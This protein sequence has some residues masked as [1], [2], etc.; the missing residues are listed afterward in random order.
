MG[1]WV[2]STSGECSNNIINKKLDQIQMQLVPDFVNIL[3]I[4]GALN[5]LAGGFVHL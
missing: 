3:A 5:L 2:N 1:N 4:K